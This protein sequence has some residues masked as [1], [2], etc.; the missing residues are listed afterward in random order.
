MRWE[1]T[2]FVLVAMLAI[3]PTIQNPD[4]VS[5]AF[6]DACT[7]G[8][9]EEVKNALALHP[10]WVNGR[11]ENGETCL[12]VA[13]IKGQSQVSRLIIEK[14]GDVNIRSEFS[15][16]LRMHPLSWNVYGGH[17]DNVRVLIEEGNVDV[18]LDYDNSKG[19]P[20]T[21]LDTVLEVVPDE[22]EIIPD[23][24]RFYLLKAL[25][26]QNGAKRY[27]DLHRP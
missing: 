22:K 24:E 20:I 9:L 21:V 6:L 15:A 11:S 4:V 1:K 27:I 8:R 5:N 7:E 16:G 17:V 14:G 13:G 19:I 25:L 23:L 10:T 2:L 12:H 26:K 18:N 3:S